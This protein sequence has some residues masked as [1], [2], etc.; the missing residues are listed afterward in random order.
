MSK[1][2][3]DDIEYVRPEITNQDIGA[4]TSLMTA[5]TVTDFYLPFI[6][7]GDGGSGTKT[8]TSEVNFG[9]CPSFA[10][11]SAAADGN[12]YGAFEYAPPSGYLALCTKNLGSDGG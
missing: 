7:N 5:V 9:G 2:I 8:G 3:Q 4:G 1:R 6:S 11:T 10:L 12:G